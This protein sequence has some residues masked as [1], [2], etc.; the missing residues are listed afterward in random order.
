MSILREFLNKI[1]VNSSIEST[2]ADLPTHNEVAKN[3]VIGAKED[4]RGFADNTNIKSFISGNIAKLDNLPASFHEPVTDLLYKSI[5]PP[6]DM[7][8]VFKALEMLGTYTTLGFTN[9]RAYKDMF[10]NQS[11][12]ARNRLDRLRAIKH[13]TKVGKWKFGNNSECKKV[14]AEFNNKQFQ[15]TIGIYS[16]Q[17][18]AYIYPG[19]TLGCNCYFS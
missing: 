1:K 15:L 18:N 14:H 4:I 5:S 9:K 12:I 7:N 6:F 13:G 16:K 17:L 3:S 11:F 19:E 8:A 2:T 10:Y